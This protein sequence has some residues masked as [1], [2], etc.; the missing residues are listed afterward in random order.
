MTQ[1]FY[2]GNKRSMQV[3]NCLFREGGAAVLLSSYPRDWL[4]AK[5][6]LAI[7]ERTHLG[8]DDKSY[9]CVMQEEDDDGVR[10]VSLSKDLMQ[11]AGISLKQNITKLG[12]RVLPLSEQLAFACSLIARKF[13]NVKVPAYVPDF[14]RAFE[15]VCIH[16]GGRGVLDEIQK[17]LSLTDWYMEPSRMSLCRFGNTSSA[18]I[19]YELSYLEAKGRIG[20]GHRV[21]QIAFGSGFKCNSAVWR[22]LRTVHAEKNLGP[23]ADCIDQ[24]PLTLPEVA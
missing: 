5:Y 12:P 17:G 22:A 24:M 15:H 1:N 20:R 16:A 13:L 4:R 2:A 9:G 3:T 19:W 10:G 14:K 23:W 8:G 6:E 11:V 21:W 7:I 18:S